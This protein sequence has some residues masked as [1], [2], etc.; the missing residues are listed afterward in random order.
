MKFSIITVNLNNVEGLKRTIDSVVPQTYKDYE[1]II[2]DGGSTDGSRELIEQYKQHIIYWC[3]E[4][5]KGIYNAMNK[6]IS[7]ANGDYLLF[8]NSGDAFHNENVL[9]EID[10]I[11]DDVDIIIG[12]VE[13]MDNGEFQFKHCRSIVMQLIMYSISHQGTFIKKSLFDT[14][15][16]N[17][18]FKIVSDKQFFL[19]TIVIDNCSYLQTNIVVADMDVKGISHDSKYKTMRIQEREHMFKMYFPPLVIHTLKD[20]SEVYY[21]P[22]YEHLIYLKDNHS[23]IF[24]QLRRFIK[25]VYLLLRK[26]S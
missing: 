5:D 22:L 10:K 19:E 3:S 4:P 16:Y 8:L 9:Q 7:H 20:Y 2:I 15:R 25:L 6:G 1:W 21:N 11:D 12:L 26:I 18:R 23:F 17:E 13:R 14:H 24:T